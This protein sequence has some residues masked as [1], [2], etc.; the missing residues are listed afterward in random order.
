M[1]LDSLLA[2][3]GLLLAAY[4]I[5]PRYRQLDLK[6]RISVA[7][8][9][10]AIIALSIVHYLLFQSFF[11][12]VG[13][14]VNL[15]YD[16]WGLTAQKTSYIVI[17][18]AGLVIGLH[19][20]RVRLTP[21]RIPKFFALAQELLWV[22]KYHDLALVLER[23]LGSFMVICNGKT[24]WLRWRALLLMHK[25]SPLEQWESQLVELPDGKTAFPI[26]SR[27]RKHYEKGKETLA[28]CIP[29]RKNEIEQAHEFCLQVF[30]HKEFVTSLTK[31]RPYLGL[32]I[33]K[34]KFYQREEFLT[35]YMDSLLRNTSSVLYHEIKN[36]QTQTGMYQYDMAEENR[37]LHT[38]V[39]D[40]KFAEEI[41]IYKPVGEFMLLYLDELS[42]DPA[43]DPYNLPMLNYHDDGKW[44]C[45]LWC[46]INF[47][48][49]M[50]TTS[51]HKNIEWHMWLYYFNHVT[52]RICRN[53]R[54]DF[55]L[56]NTV[57]E[58]PSRYSY[59]LYE[60]FSS[61]TSWV[62]A[63]RYIPPEQSNVKLNSVD[64]DNE[65]GNIPKS[66]ILAM[67]KCLKLVLVEPKIPVK[68]RLY[69]LD[70]VLSL[71]FTLMEHRSLLRYAE[72]LRNSITL[73][74]IYE[75]NDR[76]EYFR[77]L[78]KGIDG[79]DRITYNREQVDALLEFT[80]TRSE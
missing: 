47:F 78:I 9:C 38:L 62:S 53:Y 22:E 34:S 27:W 15:G 71:Y 20:I 33:I 11:E 60:M 51:L 75:C 17:F 66:S 12:K 18:T 68:F 56:R 43:N 6:L 23:H 39:A 16:Q 2:I 35:L 31:G 45:P 25:R 52:E 74:A 72:A 32:D 44:T 63:L 28:N 54:M 64:P 77:Q 50:V 58:W 76:E 24:L 10:I 1:T 14:V 70:S 37:I 48:D 57:S 80:K 61:M 41:A 21:R 36:N 19:L 5:M 79:L 49:I 67:S 29:N 40:A 8:W 30:T 69:L 3:T 26:P 59:L 46:S 13:F 73:C 55:K 42:L 65:N 4:A 7:D